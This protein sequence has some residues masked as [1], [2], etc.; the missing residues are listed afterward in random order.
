MHAVLVH[1]RK[2]LRFSIENMSQE[3]FSKAVVRKQIVSDSQ[4]HY[5]IGAGV[6]IVSRYT[7]IDPTLR[8][9]V[10]NLLLHLSC[11][12]L[13]TKVSS[14]YG[15]SFMS[16]M[17][18]YMFFPMSQTFPAMN[19]TQEQRNCCFSSGCKC[20]LNQGHISVHDRFLAKEGNVFICLFLN[21]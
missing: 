4:K 16:W 3:A 21:L 6:V 18:T 7:E 20:R 1:T 12:L 15:T 17:K 11:V 13:S 5:R 8:F 2:R 19:P 9:T 10:L 14:D